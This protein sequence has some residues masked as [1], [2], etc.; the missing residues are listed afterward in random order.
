[1][2]YPEAVTGVATAPV[3]MDVSLGPHEAVLSFDGVLVLTGG[4][5]AVWRRAAALMKV[6]ESV[7]VWL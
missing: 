2:T 3:I 1:V 7:S 6:C 5:W 4:P